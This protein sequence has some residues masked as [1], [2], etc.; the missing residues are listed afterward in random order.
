MHA[1]LQVSMSSGYHLGY[2]S[3]LADVSTY[4]VEES[5][6]VAC[7]FTYYIYCH[8]IVCCVVTYALPSYAGLSQGD[9]A[10]LD[11]IFRKVFTRGFCFLTS[12][13][14]DLIIRC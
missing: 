6:V 10:R 3:E 12:S 11:S 13:T 9:K 7:C 1:R 14:E 5:R 2:L 4:T 8:C